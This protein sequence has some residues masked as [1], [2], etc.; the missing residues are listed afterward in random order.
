MIILSKKRVKE[1]KSVEGEITIEKFTVFLSIVTIGFLFLAILIYVLYKKK[2][3]ELK[4]RLIELENFV[5][6]SGLIISNQRLGVGIWKSDELIYINSTLLEHASVLNIDLRSKNAIEYALENPEKY[7][8]VY[9]ILT[10]ISKYRFSDE[11]YFNVWRKELSGRYVEITYIRK[12]INDTMHSGLITRD[13]SSEFPNVENQ[14]IYKLTD[15]LLDEASK[16]KISIY[17]IGDQIKI[18]LTEYGLVDTFGFAF[19]ESGGYIYFPYLRYVDNYDRSGL[20]FGPEVKNLTR[21]V[22]DTGLKIHIRNSKEEERLPKGYSLLKIREEAFTV[23]AAPIIQRNI[24]RGAVLF[25]KQGVDQFSPATLLLFD[26][27]VNIL[28]LAIYFIDILEELEHDKQKF[29]ELSIKDY[30]TEAYSRRFLEQF[31][32]KELFKSKRTKSPISAVFLDINNFKQINDNYGHVYGDNILKTLVKIVKD[33]IRAMDL[34]A[35]YGGDEFVIVLPETNTEKA[36]IVID[37]IKKELENEGISISYG[38]IDA[39]IFDNIEDVYKEVDGKM[40]EMK[41]SK[42]K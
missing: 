22:I 13:V 41:N 31:L 24:T 10:T 39:S 35:R 2:C 37:R 19:L 34:I 8:N 4:E 18:L 1:W 20:R 11:E 28:T 42:R 9:D 27:I 5:S 23:Y 16:E 12:N 30:L 15:L 26:K 21:Y 33:N 36:K 7:L 25:E 14:V 40:Y 32:E 29:I 38:L 3:I 17:K 6:I